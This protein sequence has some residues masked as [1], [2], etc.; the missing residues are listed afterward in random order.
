MGRSQRAS[1]LHPGTIVAVAC[2]AAALVGPPVALVQW[3]DARLAELS[4]PEIQ[5]NWD[6]FRAEMRA[7]SD[8]S[9]PVQRKVPRSAEPPE[10]VWLR[11]Y[12]VLAVTAWVLFVGVLGSVLLGLVLGV[13]RGRIT[14]RAPAAPSLPPPEKERA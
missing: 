9:G 12:L 11:D 5:A 8:R 4:R 1:R 6:A 10:L 2:L 13:A 7:Q 3:R 14:S